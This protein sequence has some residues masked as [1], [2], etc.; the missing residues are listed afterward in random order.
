MKDGLAGATVYS[1]VQDNDGFMWFGTETGLSRF[2]GTHFKNFYTSDGLPDNEILSLF[3]DSKNRVWMIPFK[4]SICYYWKGKIHNQEN[5]SLLKKLNIT[6]ELV[7]VLEDRSGNV[8]ISMKNEFYIISPQGKISC[9][10]NLLGKPIRIDRTFLTMDDK[11]EVFFSPSEIFNIARY[12]IEKSSFEFKSHTNTITNLRSLF[13]YS[14]FEIVRNDGNQLHFYYRAEESL[15][16]KIPLPKGFINISKIS[17]SL[18]TINTMSGAYLYNINFLKCIDTFLVNQRVGYVIEDNEKNIWL[19][20]PGKGV[21]RMVRNGFL[22]FF[23]GL[24]FRSVFAI[25]RMDSSIYCGLDNFN[26]AKLNPSSKKIFV[27][28]IMNGA[29]QGRVTS[30]LKVGNDTIIVGTD[31]GLLKVRKFVIIDSST[32]GSVKFI[33][34]GRDQKIYVSLNNS[35]LSFR[36]YDI[37]IPT[38]FWLGRSTCVLES[39]GLV[40]VGTLNGLY[41]VDSGRNI[42]YLGNRFKL[43]ENRINYLAE[44]A[45]GVLW[46][47]TNG[48]GIVGYKNGKII[49]NITVKDGLTSNICRNLFLTENVIWVGTDKGLNKVTFNDT[50][51]AIT[52]FSSEDGLS[53]DIINAIYYDSGNVYVG[54][55]EGLTYFNESR[56]SQKS[57]CDLTIT[58][59][60]V[61]G[62]ELPFDSSDFILKHDENNIRFQFVGI[63]YKSAGKISYRYR[64]LGLDTA[65][66]NTKETSL[67]FQSLASGK[68]ELQLQATNKFGVQ[69]NLKEIKFEISK[70]IWEEI[71]FRLLALSVFVLGLWALIDY[72]VGRIR[73][74]EKEK[75]ETIKKIAELEQMALKSQMNPHFIFNCLNSIQHYVIDKDVMGANE[76]I[77]KFSKLIRLTLDYSSRSDISISEEIDY[78]RSY[79]ELEQMRFENKFSYQIQASNV[80]KN[81]LFIPPMILQPYIENAIRHGVRYREDNAGKIVVDINQTS[82]QLICKISDNGIGRKKAQ[83]YKSKNPIEYQS[84]GMDLTFKR[85]EMFNLSHDS[86]IKVEISDLDA[87][88]STTPG[89]LVKLY[90]PLSEIQK[91]KSAYD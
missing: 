5:D 30:L 32:Y 76:F 87:N 81:D 75:S 63:S 11:Y 27:D 12:D 41:S 48:G 89:T 80:D 4:N 22:S 7:S 65:W 67:S 16:R 55:P 71:W 61:S 64:L 42:N 52:V 3:V 39:L 18:I 60:N 49:Y 59:L 72:R 15:E 43:L 13:Y 35:V 50:G 86:K 40:F 53:S 33:F 84:K 37:K 62:I 69:S 6:T 10:N 2:D 36:F 78:I 23:S 20:S 1:M 68:Y 54:T 8:F 51:Y 83:Q 21:Y 91:H 47:A 17:D 26:L 79:F 85:I 56:I 25:A 58:S 45:D 88:E 29:T 9:V 19:S 66:R 57:I 38:L 46:V 34:K 44:S 24:E 14:D 28:K 74:R 73:K 90:F 77:S 31:L 82:E 70:T